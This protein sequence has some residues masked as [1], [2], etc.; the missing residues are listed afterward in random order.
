MSHKVKTVL[1]QMTSDAFF[2]DKSSLSCIDGEIDLA[3]LDGM[4][5]FEFLLRDFYNTEAI[6][7][8]HSL[9]AMHDCLPLNIEMTHRNM[10]VSLE[11]GR[12]SAFPDFWTGDVWK[13]YSDT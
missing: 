4:H 10:G 1:F 11:K 12:N 7:G 6:C 13:N 9:I 5:T 8:P 3:F 2:R